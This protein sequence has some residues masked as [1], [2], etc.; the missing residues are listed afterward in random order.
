MNI[1]KFF[2]TILLLGGITITIPSCSKNAE[3]R[4]YVDVERDFNVNATLNAIETHFFVLKNVPTNLDQS[5]D[6]YGLPKENITGISPADALITN[7]SGLMDWSLVTSVE[8]YAISRIDPT[9]R[10]QIFYIR[11]RDPGSKNQ[12][13]LFNTFADLSDIMTEETIDL[14]VR[15]TTIVSIPGNFT[16]KLLFNYAVFDEI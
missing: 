9:K 14:E 6:L 12:L 3:P 15:L 7:S 5:L 10:R 2:W 16:A 8:I 1:Y 11:E 4:F 13:S